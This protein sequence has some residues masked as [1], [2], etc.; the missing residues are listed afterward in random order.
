MTAPTIAE[1]VRHLLGSPEPV[2]RHRALHLAGLSSTDERLVEARRAL[3]RSPLLAA[4]ADGDPA[5]ATRSRPRHPYSKWK[6]VH[7]RLVSLMDLGVPL[8]AVDARSLAEPVL[9]WLTGR[10]HRSAIPTI[11]GL[12]RRCASQEGNALAV[13]AHFGLLGDARVELLARSLVDWQWPDGGWNC[14]RRAA[15]THF[16]VN[17]TLPAL[18]GVATFA[19]TTGDRPAGRAAERAADF[20]LRHRVGWSE[21]TGRPI[22][23]AVL[24]LHYP[25]YWHYDILAALRVLAENGQVTDPRAWDALAALESKRRPDG[26]WAAEGAHHRPPRASDFLVDVVDWR[27]EGPRDAVTLSAAIVINAAGRI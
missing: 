24:K 18:R 6:G 5:D 1:P 10:G 8:D 14:D 25:P 20:L 19:R 21:R 12:V 2:I 16:S 26:T 11:A 13:A 15:T 3:G 4:L 23:S 7:W 9:D 22:D 17:E 27:A